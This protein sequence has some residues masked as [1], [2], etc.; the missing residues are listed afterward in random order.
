MAERTHFFS[1]SLSRCRQTVICDTCHP[2][3]TI[4]TLHGVPRERLSIFIAPEV[5]REEKSSCSV[6]ISTLR[7]ARCVC[8]GLLK[9]CRAPPV[10]SYA[11]ERTDPSCSVLFLSSRISH[12]T[13]R[14]YPSLST[15]GGFKAEAL[16]PLFHGI[17]THP[18]SLFYAFPSS[19]SRMRIHTFLSSFVSLAFSPSSHFSALL[20]LKIRRVPRR[21]ACSGNYSSQSLISNSPLPP[22]SSLFF[23]YTNSTAS[24]IN[25]YSFRQSCCFTHLMDFL[26]L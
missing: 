1:L 4:A 12:R 20:G 24:R 11:G 5:V 3:G 8:H 25:T 2:S 22:P 19:R 6:F 21:F 18:S 15:E 14:P 13:L 10:P 26:P 9:F 23:L 16:S 7:T 17:T